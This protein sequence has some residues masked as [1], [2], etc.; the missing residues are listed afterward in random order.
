MKAVITV[1]GKDRTGIIASVSTLLYE[2]DVNILDISQ[3]IMGGMFTMIML[4]ELSDQGAQFA[5]VRERLMALAETMRMEI[6]MQHSDIFD[7]MHRV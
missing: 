2:E 4:V 7:A 1:L 3:T 6:R 5:K